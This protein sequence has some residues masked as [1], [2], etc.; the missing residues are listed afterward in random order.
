MRNNYFFYFSTMSSYFL[1]LATIP[2]N[3][4]ENKKPFQQVTNK[5]LVL[6]DT[7]SSQGLFLGHKLREIIQSE[8]FF[9]FQ[10][11]FW[12]K[13]IGILFN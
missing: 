11:N 9:A 4:T 2:I 8:C 1:L 6:L 13:S 3:K 5:Y 12:T 7:T 10:I